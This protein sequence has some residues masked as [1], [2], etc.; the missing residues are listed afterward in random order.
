MTIRFQ[1]LNFAILLVFATGVLP[2]CQTLNAQ[3]SKESQQ[4]NQA[5]G[6]KPKFASELTYEQ[7]NAA[8]LK[9]CKLQRTT[10]PPGFVVYHE[11]GRVLRKFMDTNK[12]K[13]LDQ[14]SYYNEGLEVYRDI[15]SNFDENLDQY[16]W[17]GPGGTR[18]GVD[19]NQAVSYTHLTLPTKA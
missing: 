16:R 12:D 2:A 14:W 13:K 3:Q 18:W 6:F 7:P 1:K 8:V 15:D 17:I 19:R 5:M 10:N 11:T 4:L 9:G